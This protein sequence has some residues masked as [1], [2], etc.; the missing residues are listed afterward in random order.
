MVAGFMAIVW[1]IW[2]RRQGVEKLW[3]LETKT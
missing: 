1:L 2:L 3:P